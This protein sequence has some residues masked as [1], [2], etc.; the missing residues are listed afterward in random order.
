MLRDGVLRRDLLDGE[1]AESAMAKVSK[2]FKQTAKKPAPKKPTPVAA[3]ETSAAPVMSL[4]DQMLAEA[5]A[6][7]PPVESQTPPQQ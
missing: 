3:P 4:S 7:T 5:A 2:H 6:E 1:E